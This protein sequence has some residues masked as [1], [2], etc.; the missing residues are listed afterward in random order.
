MIDMPSSLQFIAALLLIAIGWAAWSLR[1]VESVKDYFSTDQGKGILKGIIVVIGISVLVVL[2]AGCSGRY[3]NDA[4]LYAGLDYTEKQSPM[5]EP[6]G[7]D[8]HST[9]HVGIAVNVFESYDSRFETTLKYTHHSCAFSPDDSDY[10][11]I[12]FELDYKV[13]AR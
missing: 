1:N 11:A 5:C 13:W 4:S 10:N 2:F 9:S 8:D 3:L 7:A 12:G 6:V